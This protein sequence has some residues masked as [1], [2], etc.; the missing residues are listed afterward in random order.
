MPKIHVFTDADLDG[1][2]SFLALKL[3][4]KNAD[5]SYSVT[6]EKNF[7][8]NILNWQLKDSF[9]NYDT[10]FICDL[11]IKNDIALID[12]DNVIVFDHHAEHVNHLDEYV[13]AKAIVK[14]Y[15]SCT[16]LMYHSLKLKEKI[17]DYQ[18]LLINFISD[19]DSYV[20]KFPQSRSLN[21]IFW[22]YTGNRIQKFLIDFENG[23]NGFNQY[24]KNALKIIE[25]NIENY[26]KTQTLYK[27]NLKISGKDYNVMGGFFS[28]SPNE[29]AERALQENNADLIILINLKSKTVCYRKSKTCDLDVSKLA[30]KL[31]GGG[32][33]EAAAGSLLNDTIINISKMLEPII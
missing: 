32:G 2:G 7:R 21:Q 19:Y 20:L 6:T 4:Y 3:A 29:I 10:V 17:T 22:N 8:E 13:R 1:A 5:I 11:N 14:D 33:H 30:E 16:L 24:H 27:G 15:P 25:N 26:F 18:K 9:K 12:R 28:F 31:A 23:F